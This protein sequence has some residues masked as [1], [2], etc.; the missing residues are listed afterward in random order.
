M[1]DALIDL[2]V[3]VILGWAIIG[4]AVY[5]LAA[6]KLTRDREPWFSSVMILGLAFSCYVTSLASSASV[7][8]CFWTF[9]IATLWFLI[10]R[11]LF[12]KRSSFEM[13]MGSNVLVV[14]TILLLPA[15]QNARMKTQQLNRQYQQYEKAHQK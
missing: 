2:L 11:R 4:P 10:L 9:A 1:K 7:K 5:A 3:I 12:G 8:M 15:L 14:L 6:N 13:F